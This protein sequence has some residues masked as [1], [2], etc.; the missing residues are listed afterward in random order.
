MILESI[1]TTHGTLK[2]SLILKGQYYCV[3][4]KIYRD[5]NV[6]YSP[7]YQKNPK[8]WRVVLKKN[9]DKSYFNGEYQKVNIPKKEGVDKGHFIAECLMKFLIPDYKKSKF[10]YKDNGNNISEQS[11]LANRGFKD[12]VGQLQYEQK[13]LD[14]FSKEE[15]NVY[16]E[17]EEISTNLDGVLGR[18]IFIHFYNSEKDD[19]H[20][21]IP[22]NR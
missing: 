6:I 12:R 19:I 3:D 1:Q 14:H 21:F 17:I 7:I 10:A 4:T 22:E 16:F 9:P 20:V 8:M 2:L 15:T 18:R 11:E 5:E 13:I